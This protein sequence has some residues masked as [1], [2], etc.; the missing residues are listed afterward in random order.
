MNITTIDSIIEKHLNEIKAGHG[1]LIKEQIYDYLVDK[2][3]K[4]IDGNRIDREATR[5]HMESKNARG[6]VIWNME[7]EADDLDDTIDKII[8]DV[9]SMLAKELG[10]RD[11]SVFT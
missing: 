8:S 4:V 6:D 2:V 9:K 7:I 3:V 5:K 10:I 11:E 1:H